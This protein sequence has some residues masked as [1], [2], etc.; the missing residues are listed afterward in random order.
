MTTER[1]QILKAFGAASVAVLAPRWAMAADKIRPGSRAVLIVVD[2]QNCFVEG[3]TLPVMKGA[4]VVPV[5]N[6]LAPAF[7]NIVVTQDWHT[8]RH[9]SFASSHSGK[10][11]FE[12][13]QLSYGSQV[14]W[15]DHCVQGSEDA[16]LHKDLKLPKAQL[17]IRKGYH[18]AVDS[19]SAF[20]EADGKTPTGLSGYLKQRGIKTV[21]LTGLAT[22]FCVAWTALDARAA[23]FETSVIEDACRAIDLNG[24]LAAAWKNM[25]AKG[26]RRI[27]S[28]MIAAV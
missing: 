13:T 11:P 16:E 9:A 4:E 10:K 25:T 2:V 1:R 3:G 17:V 27:Q 21:Y 7:E 19:Y 18:Q 6:R 12:T 26:V 14:L 5:I 8:T 28:D 24:S 20:M 15:P 23:G 22:D